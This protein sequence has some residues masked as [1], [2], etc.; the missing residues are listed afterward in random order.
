MAPNKLIFALFVA[1]ALA[2]AGAFADDKALATD[3]TAKTSANTTAKVAAADPA[4]NIQKPKQRKLHDHSADKG[5]GSGRD[6]PT[7]ETKEPIKLLH[8][9]AKVHK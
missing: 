1:L 6:A 8:D 5:A 7:S 3:T 4:K 9:H 2:S